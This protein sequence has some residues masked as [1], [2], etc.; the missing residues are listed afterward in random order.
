MASEN[1]CQY[2]DCLPACSEL[3][4]QSSWYKIPTMTSRLI[5]Q[6]KEM[7]G[8]EIVEIKLWQ[9]PVTVDKPHGVKVSLVYV[10]GGK[11]LVC[12][13]NA[14]RKGYHRH[15]MEAEAPYPFTGIRQLLNDFKKDIMRIRGRR[16]DDED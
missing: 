14:E 7:K 12:Y 3:T 11:R 5:L 8:D 15:V 9:V 13:D 4:G 2:Q 10:R 1:Y 16:W 6:T